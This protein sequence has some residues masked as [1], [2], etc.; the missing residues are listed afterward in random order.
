MRATRPDVSGFDAEFAARI[1]SLW[2]TIEESRAVSDRIEA[3]LP[4]P[5]PV[6]L[7]SMILSTIA[8]R[9]K[10]EPLDVMKQGH[11]PAWAM[12]AIEIETFH[13][14]FGNRSGGKSV[15]FFSSQEEMDFDMAEEHSHI[16]NIDYAYSAHVKVYEWDLGPEY[17]RTQYLG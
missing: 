2:D 12:F 3:T 11:W 1:N 7:A 4:K 9:G 8:P 16:A 14:D 15:R 6:T 10:H 13:R 17:K 5:Q